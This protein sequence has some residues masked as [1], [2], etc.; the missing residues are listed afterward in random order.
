M[1]KFGLPVFLQFGLKIKHSTFRF[2][3]DS[4]FGFGLMVQFALSYK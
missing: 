2:S 4:A 3:Y 1:V